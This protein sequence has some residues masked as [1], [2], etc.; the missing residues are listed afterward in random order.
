[1]GNTDD[2]LRRLA[3]TVVTEAGIGTPTTVTTLGG[4]FYARVFL[5]RAVPTPVVIKFSRVPGLL[6]REATE[7]RALGAHG[8]LPTPGVRAVRDQPGRR[9]IRFGRAS[10]RDPVLFTLVEQLVDRTA[11]DTEHRSDVDHAHA[12]LAPEPARGFATGVG[13]PGHGLLPYSLEF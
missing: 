5:V 11:A 8:T 2:R 10:D 6:S 12:V 4:G 7:L 9:N 13:R 1:M 3:R